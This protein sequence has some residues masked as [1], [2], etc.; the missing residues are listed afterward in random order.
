MQS[1]DSHTRSAMKNSFRRNS[2]ISIYESRE[3]VKESAFRAAP[4]IG[5]ALRR[6][7]RPGIQPRKE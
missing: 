1:R 6:S 2:R 7:S 5:A 4:S 3:C